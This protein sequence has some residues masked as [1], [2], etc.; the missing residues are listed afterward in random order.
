MSKSFTFDGSMSREVLNNYLSR[1]VTH[2]GIGYDND[3]TSETFEDD[4]RMLKNEGAKFIGRA[5]YVWANSVPDNIGF[6]F[7]KERF[8]RGHAVDPEFIFQACVFECIYKP[9][10][11]STPIPAYVF[12]EFGLP[13]EKRC[14]SYDI[15]R[16]PE[17]PD[18]IWGRP[19]TGTPDITKTEAQMW[20][21]YR[22]AEYIR[23]GC[24]A[25]HLG[26]VCRVGKYDTDFSCWK[27][28]IRRIRKFASIHARR[29]YVLIDAHTLGWLRRDDSMFDYNAFPIRLKEIV[30]EP[31]KCICEEGYLDSMFN[32]KDGLCRPFLVE[33][34]NFGHSDKMGKADIRSHFA[35][36]YDEITW[37]SKLDAD[38]RAEFLNYIYNWVKERYPEGWVQMPSRRCLSGADRYNYS[39]NTRSEACPFGWSDEEK[40]KSI[41]ARE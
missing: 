40:I 2:I 18:N 19:P 31:M 25:I 4:L 15:M 32:E 35:W 34:D 28:V 30:D 7:A 14:F 10:V 21:F 8:A 5:A 37:F 20:F 16:I 33:F 24:E 11:D 12:E 36:G 6:A 3:L 41:F 27:S 9:F 22:S 13:V 39:A 1:A 17:E 26:Q 29:H 38:Y 23:A